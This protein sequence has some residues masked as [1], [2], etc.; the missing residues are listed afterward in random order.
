MLQ[1]I[2][3]RREV[4]VPVKI[5]AGENLVKPFHQQIPDETQEIWWVT[6]PMSSHWQP[7]CSCGIY[8]TDL[9]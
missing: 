4:T 3:E 9:F 7:P 8:I 5:S 1:N 2:G 6:V